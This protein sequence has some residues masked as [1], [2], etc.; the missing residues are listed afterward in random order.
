VV[1]TRHQRPRRSRAL[2]LTLVIAAGLIAAVAGLRGQ[3]ARF[4]AAHWRGWLE[5]VPD[6][7]APVLVGGIAKLGEPGIPV[8]VEAMGSKRESVAS[9]GKR[10]LED[11]ISRWE[12][13]PARE[14]SPKLAILAEAL[15]DRVEGFGPTARADAADLAAR[16]LGPW[17]LDGKVVDP[18]EVIACCDKVFR[19]ASDPRQLLTE[20]P[21]PVE[22]ARVWEGDSPIFPAGKSRQSPSYSSAD[23]TPDRQPLRGTVAD[24]AGVPL[25]GLSA[26]PGGGLPIVP[27]KTLRSPP[28]RPDRPRLANSRVAEP[29]RLDGIKPFATRMEPVPRLPEPDDSSG[30]PGP[31]NGPAHDGRGAK[32]PLVR[33]LGLLDGASGVD[34]VEL[35]RRLRSPEDGTVAAAQAEL[36]RRGFTETH[37]ALARQMFDP[38]PQARMRL[39]RL[40][41]ELPGIDAVPWLLELSRDE[42]AAVRLS[43]IGRMATTGDPALLE[44]IERIAAEDSDPGVKRQAERISRQRRTMR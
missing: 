33:P 8:L 13:L 2:L 7:R 21:F 18:A 34:T 26:L 41:T 32:P 17:S 15:A 23:A 42:H 27:G 10:V 16:I 1:T 11:E 29:R 43:A 5:T 9:S 3:Y 19:A 39:V 25:E 31:A 37:L 36:A 38:D 35:M 20:S 28:D 24:S 44:A 6:E 4:L 12:T 40:L 22:F 14:Y 30:G